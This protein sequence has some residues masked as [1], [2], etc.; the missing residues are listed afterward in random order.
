MSFLEGFQTNF[1]THRNLSIQSGGR[2]LRNKPFRNEIIRR[3]DDSSFDGV[4]EFTQVTRPPIS[5]ESLHCALTKRQPR[6]AKLASKKIEIRFG[7]PA[8]I[9]APL[10]QRRHLY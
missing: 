7:Q 9:M 10:A 6:P 2:V 3:Q 8:Q 5:V 4:P 1:A